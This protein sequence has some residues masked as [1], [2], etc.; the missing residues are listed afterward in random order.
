MKGPFFK[1]PRMAMMVRL[2]DKK[3]TEMK[4]EYKS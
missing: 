3:T 1:N 4:N 2:Y